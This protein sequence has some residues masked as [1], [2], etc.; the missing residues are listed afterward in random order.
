VDTNNLAQVGRLMLQAGRACVE[1]GAT[2]VF[3]H[4]M[5]KSTQL[6]RSLQ[7]EPMELPD[8]TGAGFGAVA[9]QWALV[10]YLEPYDPATGRCKVW[11]NVGGS[12]GH[13]GLHV[14]TIDE[15]TYQKGAPLGGRRWL[16]SVESGGEAVAVAN[17]VKASEGRQKAQPRARRRREGA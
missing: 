12:A 11:L 14:V 1:A 16:V 10:S 17:Q 6:Q 9:R 7:R 5:S 4:H 2:P 3:L 15:G 13:G 8:L